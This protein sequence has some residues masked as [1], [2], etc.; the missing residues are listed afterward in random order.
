MLS[1]LDDVYGCNLDEDWE[2]DG[3]DGSTVTSGRWKKLR[4]KFD[5]SLLSVLE[6][7][8]LEISSSFDGLLERLIV[9]VRSGGPLFATSSGDI[10]TP[11]VTTLRNRVGLLE[12][13]HDGRHVL[14]VHGSELL[15]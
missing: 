11:S 9:G 3:D 6:R 14:K 8:D 5:R 4:S 15:G 2:G 10:S 7:E 13:L 1:G 12:Q